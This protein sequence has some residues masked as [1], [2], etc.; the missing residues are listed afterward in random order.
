MPPNHR[1]DESCAD[2]L[3]S[4]LFLTKK[5]RCLVYT[6]DISCEFKEFELDCRQGYECCHGLRF[7]RTA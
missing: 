7:S 4:I 3:R 5:V 6:T 1:N 2:H